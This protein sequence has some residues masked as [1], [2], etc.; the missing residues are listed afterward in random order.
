MGCGKLWNQMFVSAL[1]RRIPFYE[2]LLSGRGFAIIGVSDVLLQAGD[3]YFYHREMDFTQPW[4]TLGLRF[5]VRMT[6]LFFSFLA[7]NVRLWGRKAKY[8]CGGAWL[9][10]AHHLVGGQPSGSR[11]AAWAAGHDTIQK[12]VD[13]G[14]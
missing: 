10:N 7:G 11:A 5:Y 4:C 9:L 14:P 6:G 1:E 13:D 8:A 3:A 2:I 12:D